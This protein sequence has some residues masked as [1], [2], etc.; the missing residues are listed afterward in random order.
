VILGHVDSNAGPG[1]FYLL[2]SLHRG[3]RVEVA[4]ADGST[5]TFAVRAVTVYPNA[6]FPAR[7]VYAARRGHLLNL[8]TCGGAYDKTRGGYQANVVVRTSLVRR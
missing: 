2:S 8:V 5:I 1:V 3:D 7:T 4:L 6:R